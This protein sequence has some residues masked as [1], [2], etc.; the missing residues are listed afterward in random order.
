[1]DDYIFYL[2]NFG[3]FKKL[4]G[5]V[6]FLDS[7]PTTSTGKIIRREVRELATVFYKNKGQKNIA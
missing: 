1:M 7:L 2:D 4:R 3:D 5:G 6:Y